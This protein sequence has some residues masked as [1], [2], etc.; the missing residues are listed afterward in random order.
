MAT[1]LDPYTV[2]TQGLRSTVFNIAV[3]GLWPI[4]V[5]IIDTGSGSSPSIN[6]YTNKYFKKSTL[7]A[8]INIQSLYNIVLNPNSTL[9]VS[10]AITSKS[11]AIDPNYN[12]RKDD[13][14]LLMYILMTKKF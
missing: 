3:Q 9:H 5:E 10:G 6:R 12:K 1:Y 4:P 11:E 8:M 7:A 13:E 2:A 14:D